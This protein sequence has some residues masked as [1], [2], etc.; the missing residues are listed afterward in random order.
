[1]HLNYNYLLAP[2]ISIGVIT[3][4][5]GH[6]ENPTAPMVTIIVPFASSPEYTA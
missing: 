1:M 4:E 2:P 5:N 6:I 3:T